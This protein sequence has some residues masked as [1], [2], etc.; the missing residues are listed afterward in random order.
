MKSSPR[1]SILPV[2]FDY[3]AG[4]GGAAGGPDA[5]M[6]AGLEGKLQA[7]QLPYT[8]HSASYLPS[9]QLDM[10]TSPEMKNWGR[11]LTLSSSL[12]E[13]VAQLDAKGDFPLLL[14]GDHSM[15]IGSIA[16][17]TKRRK[18]LGVLWIDAHG[19]LNTPQSSPTGNIHGMSLAVSLALGDA[20]FC[21]IRSEGPKLA[22]E[23]IVLVGARDLDDGE[24][25]L[26]RDYGIA[27]FT[28]HDI[29]RL[30]MGSVMERAIRIASEGSD[31]VHLSFDIDS[32]DP[33]EAPG[34]GTPVRG[35]LTYREA[36][37]AMEMLYQADILT[38]AELVEVN[39][40]LERTQRTA[41]L[42][43]ELIG[44]MLGEKIGG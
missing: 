25:Q 24:R 19:D 7:L 13:A 31:G 44:S 6:Q 42:A 10:R 40:L 18:R 26:I 27:C 2:P 4:R 21:N 33:G 35:G 32:V 41:K 17:L 38:S 23:R 11:V 15:A 28:M 9:V 14:G 34:T 43:V 16:G 12:A 36:H 30:G 20:R 1:I 22:P 3:G 37:L 29:D 39:P 8:V 5:V